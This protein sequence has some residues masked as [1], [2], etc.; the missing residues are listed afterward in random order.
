MS[1]NGNGNGSLVK[2]LLPRLVDLGLGGIALYFM[3][4]ITLK[5]I[6]HGGI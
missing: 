4:D 5:L 1:N 2:S 3:W 6:E